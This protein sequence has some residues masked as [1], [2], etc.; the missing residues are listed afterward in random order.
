MDYF[1][2]VCL[3]FMKPKVKYKLSKSNF[4]KEFDKCEDIELAI[5]NPDINDVDR[6]FYAYIIQQN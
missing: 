4:H 2:E 6:A 5:E 1:C 3:L